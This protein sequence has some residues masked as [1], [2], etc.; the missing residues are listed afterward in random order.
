MG[1]RELVVPMVVL[2]GAMPGQL[3]AQSREGESPVPAATLD[4]VMVTVQKIEQDV[5]EVPATVDVV[6]AKELSLHRIDSL[7]GLGKLVNGLSISS[8]TGGQPRIYLRGV[9]DAFDLKNKRIAVYVDGVPQ[10]DSTLQDPA[11]LDNVER[12]EVL[13]GPQGT[14]YG[15][16][17]SAGVINIVTKRPK[18][19]EASAFVGAGNQNQ[20]RAGVGLSKSLAEETV[21][22]G[23]NAA[24][25]KRDGVLENVAN[26][27]RGRLD[28]QERRSVNLKADIYPSERT[29]V[30]LSFNHFEDHGSPYLQTF[31]DA[32]TLKPIRRDAGAGFVPVDFYQLDR[33]TE[34]YTKTRGSGATLKISHDFDG[35]QFNAITGYQEDRLLTVSDVDFSSNPL[36]KWDFDPYTNNHKQLSQEFQLVGRAGKTRWQTGLFAYRDQTDNSNAFKTSYGNILSNSRYRT[37]G[38]AWYGQVSHEIASGW[39]ATGG[40]R[41]QR[42]RQQLVD[43]QQGGKQIDNSGAS[44][45]FKAALAYAFSPE[46]TSFLSYSTGYTP[47]GVNTSPQMING[48]PVGPYLGYAAE[49]IS[50]AEWGVKGRL[51]DKRMSYSMALYD[52][53][54]R[55]QQMLDGAD[56][57]VKNLGET[58]Y[59][60][61]EWSVDYQVSAPWSVH[62]SYARNIS[63][64]R[65]SNNAAEL[66]K[67]VPFAPRD[68]GR[69]GVQFKYPVAGAMV[70]TRLDMNHVGRI[71]ADAKNSFGQSG[72]QTYSVS[73]QA[74]FK[75]WWLGLSIANLT[76][77]RYYSNVIANS[78]F[79]GTHTA[80]Y[81][82]PRTVL[83][84][85]G[86]R[87]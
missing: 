68:S 75:H 16:N 9:G 15:R 45:T 63:V 50:S 44:G 5:L 41:H 81:A 52:T 7:E 80:L 8:Y 23:L 11:L 20:R 60:G 61:A 29:A 42:D 31:V 18:G 73:A 43:I 17:A 46:N 54:L 71:E 34:G 1:V 72:Y 78:P 37:S 4:A 35:F 66:G 57:Q 2:A 51:L 36:F 27:S 14:L 28:G 83:L 59:R 84:T 13:K 32:R 69:I 6:G 10:L 82:P 62:A 77:K 55:N 56:T 53:L 26:G 64:I 76:D 67:S 58:R 25:I 79:P 24:W 22:L 85:L 74:D 49:K 3:L 47:G 70:T 87:F 38:S 30:S 39:T 65:K 86:S 40:A 19:D 48:L 21:F 12:V 33:D